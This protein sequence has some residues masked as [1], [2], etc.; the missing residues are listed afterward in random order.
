MLV[1]VVVV[2]VTII[3]NDEEEQE[4]KK[5]D[6][7]GDGCTETWECPDGYIRCT[8]SRQCVYDYHFC[9]GIEDC[10]LGTDEDESFCGE[11]MTGCILYFITNA[12][13]SRVSISIIRI[14]D[15]GFSLSVCVCLF[16]SA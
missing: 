11:T 8:G 14:C 16:M 12:D 10:A 7:D 1:V 13:R 3:D 5:D 2:V 15:S 4:E 9:N 6:D